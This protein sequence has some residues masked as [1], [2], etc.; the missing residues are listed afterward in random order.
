MRRRRKLEVSTFP[1]L[2]V[3][4][5]A[6]GSLILVLLAMD[7][8]AKL[9]ARAKAELAARKVAEEAELLA[10]AR[11]AEWEKARQDQRTAW[12]QKRDELHSRLEADKQNLEGQMAALRARLADSAAQL[13]AELDGVGELQRNA[14][15]EKGKIGGAA[16]ALQQ[17]QRNVERKKAESAAQQAALEKM[18]ADLALLENTLRDLKAARERERQTYSVVPY[19]GRR[20]ESRRPLYIECAA[21]AVVF[22]PDKV[23]IAPERADDLRSEVLRRVAHQKEIIQ[24]GGEVADTTPY[25]MLLVRP[26]GI[27]AYYM[28]QTALRGMEAR[29]GYEFIDADWILDFPAEDGPAGTRAWATIARSDGA[30][31]VIAS[32]PGPQGVVGQRPTGVPLS[33]DG[34][35]GSTRRTDPGSVPGQSRDIRSGIGG[36]PAGLPGGSGN[37]VS[38]PGTRSAGSGDGS[39]VAPG[40]GGTGVGSTNSVPSQTG[41]RGLYPSSGGNGASSVASQTGGRGI[42]PGSGGDGTSSVASQTGLR[43]NYPGSGGDGTGSVS[44]QTGVRGIYSGSGGDGTGSASS[45]T[46]LRGNYP[47]SGGYGT[48]VSQPGSR[49]TTSGTGTGG[50]GQG[51]I[52]GS[53]SF[54]SDRVLTSGNP[55]GAG[56]PGGFGTG[57]AIAV[58]GDPGGTGTGTAALPPGGSS[59]SAMSQPGGTLS[60][61]PGSPQSIGGGSGGT[62]LP[63]LLDTGVRS[64]APGGGTSPLL[65]LVNVG[66]GTATQPGGSSNGSNQSGGAGG[67]VPAPSSGPTY[68]GYGQGRGASGN[69]SGTALRADGMPQPGS[70]PPSPLADAMPRSPLPTTGDRS[71]QASDQAPTSSAATTP[72][73]LPGQ[74]QPEQPAGTPLPTI[75]T[76]PGTTPGTA[77]GTPAAGPMRLGILPGA[78]GGGDDSDSGDPLA[79]YAPQVPR[80]PGPRKPVA[81]R[82]ARLT[83]DRDYIIYIECRPDCVVLYPS[84]RTY[85]L[86]VLS[87]SSA[88][89]NPL[90][91][92]VQQMIDRRQALLPADTPPYRPQVCFLVRPESVRTFHTAYPALDGLP[93]P[94]VRQNLD[95]EDDVLAIVTS[96]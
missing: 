61:P 20:G 16:Q 77:S 96:H 6:M 15:A 74:N 48:A 59:S 36:T 62:L 8:K 65:P 14:E 63:P 69:A 64:G 46:G 92:A 54:G 80:A 83:G 66:G 87:R 21:S 40:S 22:H 85:P 7:R 9:A 84:Q 35:D 88:S 13:R 70:G 86:A 57:T 26:N 31:S 79:R 75:A 45:Q 60:S 34:G 1:F 30:S 58:A 52:G 3:L 12:Q 90:A 49:E 44:S 73:F 71:V 10:A 43:G 11:R 76:A 51:P 53:G 68:P 50:T 67:Q 19:K 28:L 5:C 27:P 17:K 55:S 37:G 94:K 39:N 4:L 56:S 41:I 42:Y 32:Q 29:Y 78:A 38:M 95:L 23:T 93:V 47:G 82:P 89:G 33:M 81:L 18:T 24:T 91:L 2:A 72:P 25:L